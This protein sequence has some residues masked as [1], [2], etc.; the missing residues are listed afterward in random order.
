VLKRFIKG[1]DRQAAY[2]EATHLAGFGR[3]EAIKFFGRPGP[4]PRTVKAFLEPWPVAEAESR[5]REEVLA[6][7]APSR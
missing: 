5:Y 3:E 1:A 2:L 7:A 4:L 6:A